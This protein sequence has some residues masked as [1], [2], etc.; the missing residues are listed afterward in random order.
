MVF[1]KNL[2][3]TLEPLLARLPVTASVE[4]PSG[5]RIGSERSAVQLIFRSPKAVAALLDGQIGSI[6]SAIVEGWVE[7]KGSSR[8]IMAAAA[9]LLRGDPVSHTPSWLGQTVS[10]ARSLAMHTL[11][12][13]AE[14]IQ[15][16]Y[17]LSDDFYALW[18]DP[19][20]VYSCAYYKEQGMSLAQAQEAKLDHICKKL[21][22]QPG[23]RFWDIGSGWGGLIFW[24]AE[25]YGVQ[26]HGITLSRNQFEHVQHLIAEKGLQGKVRVELR[27]YRQMGDVEPFDKI[28]S[29]GMFEHVGSANLQGYF[30]T[31]Y[32]MLKPGGLALV[33]GITAGG[34]SNVELGAGMGEFIN[35]Y[36]FPGGELMH[37]SRVL[38]DLAA[39]GLEMVDTENLR[40]HYARTLWAW[41]DGL[42]ARLGEAQIIL[43]AQY[44]EEKAAKALRA[45]RLYLAGSAMGFEHGW[46][47]LHQMLCSKP[48]GD[49]RSGAMAGAQSG[50]PFNRE[51]I[52]R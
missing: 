28:G 16:H 15:F 50:Y 20:R 25:H 3:S 22:L 39:S 12:R 14:Q 6:G 36:I 8:D 45:Y 18:L 21:K 13:D 27:D 35:R 26:A 24:A 32:S 40:P 1:M 46:I 4:L 5:E 37:V 41:S 42:E 23:E 31:I 33:H 10:K 9:G 7:V 48:D 44:D 49:L 51:Y 19:R 29:V 2:L 43:Q 38:H 11:T 52:Y 17:D 47:A 34:V 30:E